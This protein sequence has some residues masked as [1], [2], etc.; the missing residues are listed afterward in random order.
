MDDDSNNETGRAQEG[1]VKSFAVLS[2]KEL[3]IAAEHC[4]MQIWR[5]HVS[6]NKIERF[7][8][9]REGSGTCMEVACPEEAL[10][11]GCISDDT[12]D[13]YLDLF[14]RIR[15]G[16][17]MGTADVKIR[18]PKGGFCWHRVEYSLVPE[19]GSA[20]SC[21]IVTFREITEDRGLLS[22]YER[23]K[24]ALSAMIS[25]SILYVEV[26][27]SENEIEHQE[28]LAFYLR[29][30]DDLE[31]YDMFVSEGAQKFLLDKARGDYLEFFDRVRLLSLY[32]LGIAEDSLEYEVAREEGGSRWVRAS[33]RLAKQPFSDDVI[34]VIV[35]IDIDRQHREIERLAHI[36][37]HDS[38]TH[39]LN[40]AALEKRVSEQLSRYASESPFALF[41]IDLD[42]FKLVNDTFGHRQGDVVLRQAADVL[43]ELFPE[44]NL[45]GRLGGDEFIAFA[46]GLTEEAALAQTTKTIEALQFTAG[47]DVPIDVSSSVG[48]ALCDGPATFD[49]LYEYADS[50]LYQAKRAGKCQYRAIRTERGTSTFNTEKS[51]A[52]LDIVQL[53]TVLEYMANGLVVIKIGPAV[54]GGFEILYAS[55]S[56]VKSLGFTR[57][58]LSEDE[59][60]E[61][62]SDEHVDKRDYPALKEAVLKAA[63]S[64]EVADCIYWTH[65]PGF[66]P[67]RK[68]MRFSHMPGGGD[69]CDY[70]IGAVAD[71]TSLAC[72][73]GE[74]KL[75]AL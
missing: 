20:S 70:V 75:R 24:T 4:C 61:L 42:N 1:T 59:L 38:L 32:R 23:W 15:A 21:A 56:Y 68:Y 72:I 74:L 73:D 17:P 2:C 10:N 35:W 64:N 48:L 8:D 54:P 66:P 28:G 50:A 44:P 26:N 7:F 18:L 30:G 52:D 43:R 67:A 11:H 9:S 63:Q 39:I 60:R 47:R 34:A 57:G 71:I 19:E 3:Q 41:I 37:T 29:S 51:I 12:A 36:A 33:V 62:W 65:V 31:K 6:E 22:E 45:L 14:R 25:E 58:E 16:E 27:L 53:R 69:E 46:P 13:A 49:E 55:P 40:R 5:Y